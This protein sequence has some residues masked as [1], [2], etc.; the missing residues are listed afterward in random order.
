VLDRPVNFR[1]IRQFPKVSHRQSP[2]FRVS[3]VTALRALVAKFKGEAK[4][5]DVTVADNAQR[6]NL[7]VLKTALSSVTGMDLRAT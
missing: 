1:D 7:D 5:A 6:S 3:D 2:A 4:P